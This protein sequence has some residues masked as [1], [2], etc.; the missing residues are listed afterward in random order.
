MTTT[1]NAPAFPFDRN[2]EH[3]MDGTGINYV[4]CRSLTHCPSICD[5][6]VSACTA[7]NAELAR[8][9]AIQARYDATGRTSTD[10]RESLVSLMS[11]PPGNFAALMIE[12]SNEAM[13][14]WQ[15]TDEAGDTWTTNSKY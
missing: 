6:P 8:E 1:E 7:E 2:H 5:C 10:P 3:C 11:R 12:A 14:W 15:Y 4:P 9:A 13:G